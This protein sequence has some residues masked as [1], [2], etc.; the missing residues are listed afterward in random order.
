M[1]HLFFSDS[2][3]ATGSGRNTSVSLGSYVSLTCPVD[4]NPE[5]TITWYKWSNTGGKTLNFTQTKADDTGC[6]TCSASNFL[7]TENITQCLL[8]GML[9]ILKRFKSKKFSVFKDLIVHLR[10]HFTLGYVPH[11]R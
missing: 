1:L 11:P 3:S 4:G 8:V 6:Y 10:P 9:H 7:G 5:P 2:P